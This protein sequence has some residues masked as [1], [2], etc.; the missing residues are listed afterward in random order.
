MKK[1]PYCGLDLST[2]NNPMNRGNHVRWCKK[3]TNRKQREIKICPCCGEKHRRRTM[4]CGKLECLSY[5]K[6]HSDITRL[7]ISNSLKRAHEENRHPGWS[8]INED[9]NKRSYPERFFIDVL[10]NNNIFDKFDIIEK[11]SF[12][13]YFL[14]FAFIDLLLDVEIDGSQHYRTEEAINHDIN[15][16]EFMLKNG[17]NVYRINWKDMFNNTQKEIRKFLYYLDNYPVVY[18]LATNQLKG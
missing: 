1:C 15:R 3:N 17:W 6:R 4:Y 10:K 18:P 5:V 9:V 14:D 2:I 7:K 13:K 8:H 16:N 12:G 11:Y